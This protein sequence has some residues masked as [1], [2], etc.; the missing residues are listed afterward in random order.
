VIVMVRPSRYRYAG[1]TLVELLVVL[2]IMALLTVTVVPLLVGNRDKKSVKNAADAAESAFAHVA[3]KAMTSPNGVAVWLETGSSGGG[4]G[5]AVNSIGTARVPA[6]AYGT[7]TI[8]RSVAK[9]ETDVTVAL[10]MASSLTADLPAPIDFAGVPGVFT[11][12]STTTVTSTSTSMTGAVN[13]TAWNS[14]PPAAST[15]AVPYRLYLPPRQSSLAASTALSGGAAIDL[16]ASQIGFGGSAISLKGFRR[17]AVEYDRTGCPSAAWM[18]T[19]ATGGGWTREVLTPAK[20]IVLA[21]GMQAQ[22]GAAWVPSP[23]EDDPGSSWQSPFS[24]WLI[25]DPRNG[26][27]RVV[28]AGISKGATSSG[29][30]FALAIAPVVEDFMNSRKSQK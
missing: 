11:A 18:S 16:S 6:V 25:I 8:A 15:A 28:E 22:A 9:P 20:P 7:T 13:R 26:G 4:A 14:P 27:V 30:A 12:E 21:I 5:F 23:T 19:S 10:S 2:V 24:R 29:N 3:T 1:M 17:V